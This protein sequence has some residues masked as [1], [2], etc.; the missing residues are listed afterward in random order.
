MIVDI[1]VD[2]EGKV[3]LE[4]LCDTA[5]RSNGVKNLQGVSIIL[6]G[7]KVITP[8]KPEPAK[9]TSMGKK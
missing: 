6:S 1:K 4:S 8:V 5:L 3:L 9:N 7:M 2:K